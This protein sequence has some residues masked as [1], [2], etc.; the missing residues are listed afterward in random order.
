MKYQVTFRER[1]D[2]HGN[3]AENP[4]EFVEPELMDGIVL[5][6]ALVERIEP[7]NLHGEEDMEE[8]DDFLSLGT[9]VWEYDIADGR[10]QEFEDAL[11]NSQMVMEYEVLDDSGELANLPE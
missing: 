6:S 10:G 5:D 4:P 9:E 8:D 3:P 11:K 1:N 7:E 2:V